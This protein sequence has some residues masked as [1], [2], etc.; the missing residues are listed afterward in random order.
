MTQFIYTKNV[1]ISI[2]CKGWT[3]RNRIIQTAS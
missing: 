3:G 2:W 1:N